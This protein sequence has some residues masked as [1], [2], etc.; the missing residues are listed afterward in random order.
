MKRL[1]LL[2]PPPL[3][4]LLTGLLMWLLAK[5]FPAQLVAGL[6]SAVV[7][8]AIALLGFA[9]S[10]VATFPFWHARTTMDPKHPAKAST[11][12]SAGIYR[13]SRNPRYLGVLIMLVGWAIYLGSLLSILCVFVFV[14]YLT[15]FQILP[16]E[17]LLQEKFG[18]EFVSYKHSV[19][20]WL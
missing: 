6:Q 11:L 19:R 7:A 1:E 8:V 12:I 15:R 4:M 5:M 2:I 18:T 3:V 13:Y 14:A 20:R 9:I 16:E 10:L 17:R